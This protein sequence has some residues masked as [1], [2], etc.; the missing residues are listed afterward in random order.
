MIN[1]LNLQNRHKSLLTCEV[2]VQWINL[3]LASKQAKEN[4]IIYKDY[5][6]LLMDEMIITNGIMYSVSEEK[7]YGTTKPWYQ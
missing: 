2:G 6:A 3:I 1:D 5:C 7:V 4:N